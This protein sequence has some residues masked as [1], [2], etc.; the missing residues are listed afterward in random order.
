MTV[1]NL[2]TSASDGF[3]VDW[4]RSFD[5]AYGLMDAYLGFFD[6]EG[7]ETGHIDYTESIPTRFSLGTLDATSSENLDYSISFKPNNYGN[8]TALSSP[9]ATAPSTGEVGA[10]LA[11]GVAP[12]FL[13][14]KDFLVDFLDVPVADILVRKVFPGAITVE[15]LPLGL[16]NPRLKGAEAGPVTY[17]PWTFVTIVRDSTVLREILID[18]LSGIRLTESFTVRIVNPRDSFREI[19]AITCH[20]LDLLS[21]S[22]FGTLYVGDH[23]HLEMELTFKPARCD[24]INS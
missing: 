16:E 13:Q 10:P 7:K 2:M 1:E 24:F 6:A 9:A 21:Y 17:E 8:N 12:S 11:G 23:K 15:L 14:R 18:T 4:S 3:I 20:G 19:L 22:P 5:G